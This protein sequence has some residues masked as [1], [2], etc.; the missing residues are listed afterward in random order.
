MS[1]SVPP[2]R[3]GNDD[4][5]RAEASTFGEEQVRQLLAEN[6]A[7][8]RTL[9]ELRLG[10]DAHSIV[11]TTDRKGNILE[12]ND[13][14]TEISK[15]SR[16][17][18]IGAPQSIVNSGTHPRSF[19]KSMW[20]TIG[21]GQIWQGEICNR[22][23]DGSKYWV[24][25]TIVPLLGDD[26]RPERYLSI[27][28]DVTQLRETEMRVRRLAYF[29]NLTSM[30]N[31]SFMVKHLAETAGAFGDELQAYLT[32]SLEDLIT[33]NDAFGYDMGDQTLR[34]IARLLTRIG[35]SSEGE[36]PISLVPEV[37]ARVGSNAF[38]MHFVGLG[39]DR[40]AAERRIEEISAP[41]VRAVNETVRTCLGN[42]IEADLRVGYVLYRGTD[43]LDGAQ[44][45]TRAEIARRRT[46]VT[47]MVRQ[48]HVFDEQMILDTQDRV[49]LIFDLRRGVEC[50]D[51]RLYMQPIVGP[52]A[53]V[54]GFEG[55]LRWEDAT[56]GLVRPD[57]F[58]PLAEST[59][60][61]VEIGAWVL[62][63]ACRT[64]AE[65]A[66]H[67]RT[68]DWFVAVNVSEQQLRQTDFADTVRGALRR[69]G[70]RP[71]LLK[72]EVTETM[73][74]RDV[75]RTVAVLRELR[76]EQIE[77][78]LDDFGVGYSSLEYLKWLPV[79]NLKID[80]T[81]IATVVED[82]LDAAMVQAMVNLAH[83]MGIN[84]V[85][86]GVETE[87]QF[88]K[89]REYGVDRFQGFLFGKPE[90]STIEGFRSV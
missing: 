6:T 79:Q 65:W 85:A 81:F 13:R 60:M 26:G 70:A 48:P 21:R 1:P 55:L 39:K 76:A 74:H 69:H 67:E 88:A 44:V 90:P 87:A 72:L 56:R 37:V 64:L 78:S 53:G 51:L 33:I 32:L 28:T 50:G 82:P 3:G 16:D 49:N 15:Y 71:E 2:L 68:R 83:V 22:A 61:I 46:F 34:S 5:E 10:L 23:K 59:G 43:Q 45:F 14:F 52:E 66:G 40:A 11:A 63:E 36:S 30:P 25:T 7:L 19:F 20:A 84:V 54:L 18:L 75:D 89:L 80:R 8:E 86:E 38:G 42:V 77:I 29:D 57:Q 41:L 35:E 9:T 73:I 31:Q 58:I 24:A 4:G 47:K 62:D 12:V 27:R 17:E